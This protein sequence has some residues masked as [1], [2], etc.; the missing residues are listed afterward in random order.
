MPPYANTSVLVVDDSWYVHALARDAL[1]ACGM[2]VHCAATAG[3]AIRLYDELHPGLVLMDVALPDLDGI[4]AATHIRDLNPDAIILIVSGISDQSIRLRARQAG[5]A[6][7]ISKPVTGRE[8]AAEVTAALSLPH[9][10]AWQLQ[11]PARP[12]LVA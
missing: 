5:I 12:V 9:G 8:L 10:P 3:D 1:E 4:S 7:F 6:R 11:Q 2:E